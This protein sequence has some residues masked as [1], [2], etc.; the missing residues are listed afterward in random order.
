[1]GASQLKIQRRLSL[2]FRLS[3]LGGCRKDAR[4]ELVLLPL[5]AQAICRKKTIVYEARNE[6]G[7]A[8]PAGRRRGA[9]IFTFT[10]TRSFAKDCE[11]RCGEKSDARS[12]LKRLSE[13]PLDSPPFRQLRVPVETLCTL[14]STGLA[15]SVRREVRSSLDGPLGEFHVIFEAPAAR[16]AR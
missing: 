13:T 11:T 14:F 10:K 4:A 3:D 7:G 12:R 6:L 5:R 16:A 9:S 1:M 2:S 8:S 15:V